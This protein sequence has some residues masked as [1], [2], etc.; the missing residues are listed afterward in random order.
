MQESLTLDR[1]RE[2]VREH[3]DAEIVIDN[4]S[5][6]AYVDEERITG[7]DLDTHTALVEVLQDL[8]LPA[9]LP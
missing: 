4:D 9:V 6:C 5:W 8:G 2:I 7:G 3:P 1:L